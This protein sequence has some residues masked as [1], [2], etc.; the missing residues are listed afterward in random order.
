MLLTGDEFSLKAHVM[1]MGS[2]GRDIGLGVGT[3]DPSASFGAC[4]FFQWELV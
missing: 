1:G 3:A 4:D 2:F